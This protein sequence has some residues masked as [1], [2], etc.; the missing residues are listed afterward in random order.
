MGMERARRAGAGGIVSTLDP[1]T[2]RQYYSLTDDLSVE[3]DLL[4]VG[5]ATTREIAAAVGRSAR[6]VYRWKRSARQQIACLHDLVDRHLPAAAEDVKL[7][8]RVRG[9]PMPAWMDSDP[10]AG[11]RSYPWLAPPGMGVRYCRHAPEAPEAVERE[12]I[13]QRDWLRYLTAGGISLRKAA[14]T[15]GVTVWAVRSAVASGPEAM[16]EPAD[17]AWP[18]EH[19]EAAEAARRAHTQAEAYSAMSYRERALSV[20]VPLELIEAHEAALGGNP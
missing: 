7:R 5:E 11:Q 6:T 16:P 19:S 13:A 15:A 17:E 4:H 18:G 2:E 1:I 9:E 10:L 3:V 20:G 8:L 14:R 12:R